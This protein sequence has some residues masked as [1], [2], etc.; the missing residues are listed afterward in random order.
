MSA[1]AER[2]T[3]VSAEKARRMKGDTDFAAL[4][5]MTDADIARAAA[6]TA[7]GPLAREAAHPPVDC[8]TRPTSV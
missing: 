6:E 4:D 7:A 8:Q 2:I 1:R 3:R 5:A